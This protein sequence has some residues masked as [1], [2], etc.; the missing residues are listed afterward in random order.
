MAGE[1][2][3]GDIGQ[4][5]HSTATD[6]FEEATES[7]LPP[8]A[9]FGEELR[10]VIA[11]LIGGVKYGVKIRFP[12]AFIMTLLF[13]KDLSSEQKIRNIL[14]LV[15]EHASNLGLFATIYK[16]RCET[17]TLCVFGRKSSR[18]TCNGVRLEASRIISARLS[19]LKI[20]INP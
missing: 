19:H 17:T 4:S 2:T 14:K 15:Y 1:T 5:F 16:V 6:D 13:R 20:R 9:T 11:G 18:S 8:S 7:L 3:H 10:A 12:H